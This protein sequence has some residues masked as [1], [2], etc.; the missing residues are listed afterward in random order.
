MSHGNRALIVIVILSL[1]PMGTAV[2][3]HAESGQG[4][5]INLALFN[6][7]QIVPETEDVNGLRLSLLYG[8]NRNM[9][10][11]DV[12]LVGVNSGLFQGVQLGLVSWVEGDVT[13]L[14]WATVG[15]THGTMNGVQLGLYNGA[16]TLEGFQWGAINMTDDAHG[17]QLALLN[18]TETLH[19]LQI[20]LLNFAK[21]GF[22]P[23][24]PIFNFNF[25]D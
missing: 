7:V 14:Q 25:D 6:P 2:R 24:F 16:T 12:S 11:L 10:G 3:A 17:L 21:N 19:G 15:Q 23:F 8:K 9:T 4:K 1:L 18:W 13:G 22:L 5:P 20:G